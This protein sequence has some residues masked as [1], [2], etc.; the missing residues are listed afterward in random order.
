MVRAKSPL[1][2]STS[3]AILPVQ[4]VAVKRQPVGVPGQTKEIRSLPDQVERDIGQAEVDLQR[5]R[6]A[7]PLAE[8]LA[9]ISA[10][11]PRRC[12]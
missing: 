3:Q 9:E 4:H 1:G 10:S 8:P 5:R 2:C 6:M 7:A 12:T 11:S